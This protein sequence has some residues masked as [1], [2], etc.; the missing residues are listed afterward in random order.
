MAELEETLVKKEESSWD[1]LIIP[2]TE[3]FPF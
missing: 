3:N 1:E 2:S